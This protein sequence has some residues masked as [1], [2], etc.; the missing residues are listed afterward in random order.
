MFVFINLLNTA[1]FSLSSVEDNRTRKRFFF[2][3]WIDEH[4]FKDERTNTESFIHVMMCIYAHVYS[5]LK[6]T[7]RKR[8]WFFIFSLAFWQNAKVFGIHE[9]KKYLFFR[10]SV[11]LFKHF[12]LC[13][14]SEKDFKKRLFTRNI[15]WAVS[16]N[17][18]YRYVNAFIFFDIGEKIMFSGTHL[19]YEGK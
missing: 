15:P 6:A 19:F 5:W 11:F 12:F 3:S 14:L 7:E 1:V 13:L 17:H 2:V 18:K 9:V 10:T 4:V 8:E 16:I